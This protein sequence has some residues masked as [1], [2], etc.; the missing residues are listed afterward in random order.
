MLNS[1]RL[2]LIHTHIRS[3]LNCLSVYSHTNTHMKITIQGTQ[4]IRDTMT[5]KYKIGKRKCYEMT[6]NKLK[7]LFLALLLSFIH[8][9]TDKLT[10]S[11]S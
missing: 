8:K 2:S 1:A 6:S 9:R 10:L 7:V 11:L 4:T 5:L 3:L